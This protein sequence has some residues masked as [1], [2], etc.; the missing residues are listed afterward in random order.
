MIPACIGLQSVYDNYEPFIPPEFTVDP[1]VSDLILKVCLPIFS[2]PYQVYIREG[3]PGRR[4]CSVSIV[5]D[6]YIMPDLGCVHA[7]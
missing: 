5:G 6:R 7:I 1:E 3:V 4:N 2:S